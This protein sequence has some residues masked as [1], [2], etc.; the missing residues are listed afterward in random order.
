MSV[1]GS[2]HQAPPVNGTRCVISMTTHITL[3][4]HRKM[5]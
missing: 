2:N 4:C 5:P 1:L 3:R